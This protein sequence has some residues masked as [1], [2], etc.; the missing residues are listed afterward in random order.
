MEGALGKN[1]GKVHKIVVFLKRPLKNDVK[2]LV[3]Q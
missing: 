1:N 3:K 2:S